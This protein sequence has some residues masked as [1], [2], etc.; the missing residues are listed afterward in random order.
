MTWETV[1]MEYV[2]IV[3][4]PTGFFLDPAAY[5]ERLPD[6]AA[7][8]PPGAARFATD[9]DHYSF[10]GDR[11]IKDLHLVA[12]DFARENRELAVTA[13]FS[14]HEGTPVVLTITY[15]RVE[16]LRLESGE[17]PVQLDETLPH[18]RGCRHEIQLIGGSIVVVCA[19]FEAVWTHQGSGPETSK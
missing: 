18:E 7:E 10:F 9:P 5:L 12:V 13:R 14:W 19:D 2:K 16:D 1:G 11:C 4:E 17:G 15:R 3:P 8:L 6:L